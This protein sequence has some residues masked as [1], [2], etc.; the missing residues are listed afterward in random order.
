MLKYYM[1]SRNAVLIMPVIC[2][3]VTGVALTESDG[4]DQLVGWLS[5]HN[6]FTLL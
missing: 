6:G 1:L 2:V 4:N 5:L 3:R